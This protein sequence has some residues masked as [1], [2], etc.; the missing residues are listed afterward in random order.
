L[1]AA[2]E[3]GGLFRASS[4]VRFDKDRLD[5]NMKYL[6]LLVGASALGLSGP[7]LA[8]PGNGQGHGQG[9]GQGFAYGAQGPMGYG[10]GG[11]PPGLAKKAT[12]CVPPGQARK[13]Y[14][15]GQ[16]FPSG[17]GSQMGYSQIPYNV[18][19]RYRLNSSGNYYYSNGYLYRVNPR[20][21]LIQ[22]VVSALVR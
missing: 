16:R 13:L 3:T 1:K 6:V 20:T 11:C 5:S 7:A 12:P 18:R 4:V 2:G 14:N 15:V 21:M 9:H 10:A 22:Q 19:S 8:K 17:Y